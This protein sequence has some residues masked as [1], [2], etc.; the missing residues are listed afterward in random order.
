MTGSRLE[1]PIIKYSPGDEV[2]CPYC[3]ARKVLHTRSEEALEHGD[4]RITCGVCRKY[5][6]LRPGY[7]PIKAKGLSRIAKHNGEAKAAGM[8]YGQYMA[9]KY[10]EQSKLWGDATGDM[11][12]K[13]KDSKRRDK[14][15]G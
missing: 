15:D 14:E 1:A 12:D 4:A 9:L 6:I 13:I 8:S 5:F 3:L 11:I 10:A 7:K 2:Y